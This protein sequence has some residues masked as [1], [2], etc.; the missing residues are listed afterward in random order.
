MKFSFKPFD[1]HISKLAHYYRHLFQT[2]KFIVT[3]EN[4]NWDEKYSYVRMIRG[5]LSDYEQAMIYYNACWL[6]RGTWWQDDNNKLKESYRYILDYALIKNI[7]LNLTGEFGPDAYTVY[8]DRLGKGPYF[9]NE[10]EVTLQ[11]KLSWLFESH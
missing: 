8:K 6:K 7:P 10:E 4:T 9:I 1:G 2:I 5:Q 11:K 3:Y